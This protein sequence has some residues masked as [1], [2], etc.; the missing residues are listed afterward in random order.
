MQWFM[1]KGRLLG[2]SITL[3]NLLAMQTLLPIKSSDFLAGTSANGREGRGG[4][5]LEFSKVCISQFSP[6]GSSNISS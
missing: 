1:S 4:S 2:A 3:F 5:D 6:K